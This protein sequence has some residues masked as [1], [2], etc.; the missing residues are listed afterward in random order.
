MSENNNKISVIKFAQE[1]IKYIFN[2]NEKFIKWIECEDY[3][4]FYETVPEHTSAINFIL[5]NLIKDGVDAFDFWTLKKIALDYLMYGGFTLEVLKTRSN[6][7]VI[8]YIDIAKTR[9]NTDKTKIGFAENWDNYKIEVNW[10][11]ITENIDKPGIYFFKNPLS[12]DIYPKPHYYSSF[13]SLDTA[14]EI[15][16]HHNSNAKNGFTPS[17][18]IN[19]NNGQVDEETKKQIEK[20]IKEKF[21]GSDGQKFL[22][23]FNDSKETQTEIS[24]LENDNLDQKFETLQK[25]IQ[26]QIIIAHQITSGQLIGVKAENQGFSKTEYEESLEIFKTVVV[27]NYQREIE[28]GLSKLLNKD[29]KLKMD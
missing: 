13:I 27:A 25:F 21:T 18:V 28:Y 2:P 12:K 14:S 4:K 3:K 6:N 10:S 20:S 5:F 23:S 7:S 8:K 15:S 22:L 29:I 26:N 11:N 24:K 16:G 1:K 19:F 17:A 9:L